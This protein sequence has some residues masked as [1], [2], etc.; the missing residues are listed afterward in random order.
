MG[1]KRERD[2]IILDRPGGTWLSERGASEPRNYDS[3]KINVG[4]I[5][6]FKSLCDLIVLH[7]TL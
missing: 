3:R 4:S 5:N 7:H 6:Y 1:R 2:E